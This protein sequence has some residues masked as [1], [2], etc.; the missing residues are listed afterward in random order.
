MYLY[1]LAFNLALQALVGTVETETPEQS[2][3]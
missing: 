1:S 2:T 3:T